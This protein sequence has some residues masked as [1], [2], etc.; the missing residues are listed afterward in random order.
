MLLVR[1]VRSVKAKTAASEMPSLR[2]PILHFGTFRDRV[3][4]V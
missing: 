4:E 2:L 1:M 3:N